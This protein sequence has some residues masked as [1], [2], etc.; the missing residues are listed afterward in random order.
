M[1]AVGM[2]LIWGGYS[3]GLWGW[4]L[5]RDYD[6]T[7][8]QLTSPLHPYMSNKG[9]TWPPAK[10]PD[11]QIWPGGAP[12]GSKG[13]GGKAPSVSSG[14]KPPNPDGSCPPGYTWDPKQKL[15]I[16]PAAM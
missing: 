15:C 10:I 6:V 14:T 2:L 9:D 5:L 4:C 16:G 8:G 1:V 12:G 13:G 11:T 7:F 3:A